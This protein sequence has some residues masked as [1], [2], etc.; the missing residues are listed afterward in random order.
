M[1]RTVF[2]RDGG[3]TRAEFL[4]RSASGAL[5]AFATL[6]VPAAWAANAPILTRRIPKGGEA[7]PV[8]GLGTARSFGYAPD[9]AAFNAR[10]AALDALL[11]GGGTV[12]DTSPTYGDSEAIVGRALHELGARERAFIATK[13]STTGA[14]AGVDQHGQSVRDLRTGTFDLL[15][16]HN[17]RDTEVHLKTAR[18][19]KEQARIRYIGVTHFRPRAYDRLAEVLRAE[20]LDFVQ[21]GYSIVMREAER[22]LLPLARDRGVAVLVNVPYARGRLFSMVR[23]KK[24]PDW[25]AEFDAVSWGQFFLKFV[26]AHDAVTAAIPGAVLVRH[27]KDNLD[28][29]RGRLPTAD[30]RRRMV[31]FMANL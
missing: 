12:I 18:R 6:S 14:Q 16:I 19:L 23:G 2:D 31:E 22:E 27:V 1:R 10:K 3:L 26:I 17:L 28:A 21:L 29:G 20:P 7:V 25:A 13:I 4:K 11:S 15:Q 24:L 8:V 5:G 9:I 30:H